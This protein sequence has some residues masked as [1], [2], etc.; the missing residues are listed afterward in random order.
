[1][2]FVIQVEVEVERVEGKFA[3]R[4]EIL[5]QILEAIESADPGTYEGDNGG[6]Y[7]TSSW[8][9]S[10]ASPPSKADKAAAKRAELRDPVQRLND[11]I[12]EGL[13]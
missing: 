2:R 9:V 7:E 8:D 4:D 13:S 10:D 3:G 6:Q 12:A 1:M 5:T 11:A